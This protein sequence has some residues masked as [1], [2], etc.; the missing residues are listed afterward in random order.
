MTAVTSPMSL[1]ISD[2]TFD[3]GVSSSFQLDLNLIPRTFF[4]VR[5][6][7]YQARRSPKFVITRDLTDHRKLPNGE[8][9]VEISCIELELHNRY[10]DKSFDSHRK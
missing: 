6:I 3:G 9:E 8:Q 4:R 10:K 2:I 7:V 5:G 1:L